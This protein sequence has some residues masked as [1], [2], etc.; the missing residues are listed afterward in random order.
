VVLRLPGY[1]AFP[2]HP[3]ENVI[4]VALHGEGYP[5][6]GPI[7]D[8]VLEKKLQEVRPTEEKR[9]R[10]FFAKYTFF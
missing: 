8:A 5:L 4:K 6:R 10:Q 1:Y 7:D 3:K 2:T 9:F